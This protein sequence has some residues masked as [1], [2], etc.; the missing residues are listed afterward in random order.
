M[1]HRYWEGPHKFTTGKFVSDRPIGRPVQMAQQKELVFSQTA[2]FV[3][4]L[5][6]YVRSAGI[7]FQKERDPFAGWLL[8]VTSFDQKK[9]KVYVNASDAGSKATLTRIFTQAIQGALSVMSSNDFISLLEQDQRAFSIPQHFI[10]NKCGK[11]LIENNVYWVYPDIVL[12]AHGREQHDVPVFIDRTAFFKRGDKITIPKHISHPKPFKNMQISQAAFVS[13][14]SSLKEYFGARSVHALHLLTAV[15]KALLRNKLLSMEHQISVTNISGPPNIGKTL[16]CA[17]ATSLLA[18]DHLIVSKC[19]PSAMLDLADVFSHQL[20]VYDDPRDCTHSMLEAIVHDAFHGKM[21]T[22]SYKGA[23][24]YNAGLIIGTQKPFYGMKGADAQPTLSRTTHIDMT[25]VKQEPASRNR[26]ETLQEAMQNASVAF[27]ALLTLDYTTGSKDQ[28]TVLQDRLRVFMPNILERSLR[29]LA[30]DWYWCKQ[31]IKLGAPWT[32]EEL[33][34]YIFTHQHELLKKV[35]ASSNVWD[36]FVKDIQEANKVPFPSSAFKMHLATKIHGNKEEC[37]AFHPKSLAE[38]LEKRLGHLDY[39][40][41]NIHDHVKSSNGNIGLVG[42]N[43]N[44][45]TEYNCTNMVQRSIVIKKSL[46][47]N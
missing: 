34:T 3:F 10:S 35:C 7:S 11:V 40:M 15:P 1:L 8:D 36:Q 28:V 33:E 37:I 24:S 30:G 31:L 46:I 27:G 44:Y 12:D 29:I 23:R 42:Q 18:N 21:S 2:N 20:V 38:I 4:K 41:E 5:H 43:V 32:E 45:R 9:H 16:L 14:C 22:T 13:L 19:T 39:S 25:Q 6:A 26:E 17:A 47:F